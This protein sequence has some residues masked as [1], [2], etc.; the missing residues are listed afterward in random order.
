MQKSHL[1]PTMIR[2]LWDPVW[3]WD[4]GNDPINLLAF[5]DNCLPFL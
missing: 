2:G 1:A 5:K 4:G 3:E